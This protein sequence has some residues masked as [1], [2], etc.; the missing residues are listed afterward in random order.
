MRKKTVCLTNNFVGKK[1]IY[2]RLGERYLSF[3]HTLACTPACLMATMPPDT[4]E[5]EHDY[6][7]EA[8]MSF[9]LSGP[10][11]NMLKFNLGVCMCVCLSLF[12]ASPFLIK[13]H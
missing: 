7:R 6:T 4:L 13:F 11:A 3:L 2:Q 9:S 8:R 5:T 1:I 12:S 10:G